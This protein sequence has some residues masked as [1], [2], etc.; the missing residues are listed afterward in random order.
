MIEHH[1][2]AERCGQ[3]CD[4]DTVIT[5]CHRTADGPGCVTAES[6]GDEPFPGEQWFGSLCAGAIPRRRASH[7]R[8]RCITLRSRRVRA[9]ARTRATV[10]RA[11]PGNGRAEYAHARLRR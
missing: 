11:V 3:R 4:E 8:G 9:A 7:V 10:T 6:V 1:G 2:T 5:A